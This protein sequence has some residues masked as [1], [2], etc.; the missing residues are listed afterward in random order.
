MYYTMKT[1]QCKYQTHFSI[2]YELFLKHYY[3]IAVIVDM[4]NC[5]SNL[6]CLLYDC[7]MMVAMLCELNDKKFD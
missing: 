3:I 2:V 6:H 7:V 4:I 5:N 1:K